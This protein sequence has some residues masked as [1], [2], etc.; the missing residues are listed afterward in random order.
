MGA[1]SEVEFEVIKEAKKNEV[2]CLPLVLEQ[3]WQKIQVKRQAL[4]HIWSKPALE[5]KLVRVDTFR[6]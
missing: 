4:W 3:L 2:E 6:H 5:S 1:V